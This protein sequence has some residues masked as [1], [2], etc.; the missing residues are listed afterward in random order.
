MKIPKLAQNIAISYL[1]KAW[2]ISSVYIFIPL[3]VSFLGI[4]Q[5]G[6]VAFYAS[7]TGLL[8]IADL[9]IANIFA[10]QIARG[11]NS[12][13]SLSERAT[14][15]KSLEFV[16]FFV[17]AIILV[18]CWFLSEYIAGNW[19]N[20]Q[21]LSLEHRIDA[22]RLMVVGGVAQLLGS[23]YISG[24]LGLERQV[25]SNSI[26]FFWG[27]LK[28]VGG[29]LILWLYSPT[30]DTF[31][32]WQIF[33][34][35]VYVLIARYCLSRN[36]SRKLG[37]ISLAIL[38]QNYNVAA[39]MVAIS[40]LASIN[41][42]IDKLLVSKH[43]DVAF[44]GLYSIAATLAQVPIILANPVSSAI[45]PRLSRLHF[46]NQHQDILHTYRVVTFLLT[47]A[48]VSASFSIALFS[49][50]IL[51]LW[52]GDAIMASNINLVTTLLVLGNMCQAIQIMPFNL[53]ISFGYTRATLINTILFM[54]L[55]IIGLT[56]FIP[57][58]GLMGAALSWFIINLLLTVPYIT[59]T[60]KTLLPGYGKHF[61]I[62]IMIPLLIA[63][64][65]MM[66]ARYLTSV[67]GWRIVLLVTAA[68]A[69]VVILSS[70]VYDQISN[71]VLSKEIKKFFI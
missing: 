71:G 51:L 54:T 58:Y 35:V 47:T 6:L 16:Y 30:V 17:V 8:M 50:E 10:R 31:L 68:N 53:S 36:V 49:K 14:L 23:F 38:K 57:K 63:P 21:T 28:G 59:F 70:I 41:F 44:F 32:Q 19:L 27:I 1:G 69:I 12:I 62:T 64:T 26:Q 15:L 46:Q 22:V 25:T 67:S 56:L 13:T 55:S 45:M 42:Q 29:V 20:S 52:T 33:S 4:E 18:S 9:G 66:A 5:Y 7:L 43:L 24:L 39:G 40:I 61:F 34:N 3:Y 48:M 60:H 2:A 11:S 37:R 65:I